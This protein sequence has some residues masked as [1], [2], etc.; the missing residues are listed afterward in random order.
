MFPTAK[1]R[2]LIPTIVTHDA[3]GYK[4]PTGQLELPQRD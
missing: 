4:C 3:V 1:G 2:S